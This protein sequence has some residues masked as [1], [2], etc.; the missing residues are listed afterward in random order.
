MAV[1]DSVPSRQNPNVPL[2]E[3]KLMAR[4]WKEKFD[5]SKHLNRMWGPGCEVD[6][7]PDPSIIPK[8]VYF[9]AVCSFTFEFHSINQIQAC[10]KYYSQKMRPCTRIPEKDLWKYGGDHWEVHSWF[11]KLPQRLLEE[12]KRLKVVKALERSLSEFMKQ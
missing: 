10:L 3:A 4:C 1:A 6:E 9:V 12:P 11:E 2:L 5:S 8:W 7:N